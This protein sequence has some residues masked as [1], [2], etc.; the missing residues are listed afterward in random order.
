[1]QTAEWFYP[2]KLNLKSETKNGQISSVQREWS[3]L[4]LFYRQHLPYSKPH[5]SEQLAL[6]RLPTQLTQ[7]NHQLGPIQ[8][9]SLKL[10]SETG[11]QQTSVINE[12]LLNE[13]AKIAA[14]I[15][16]K[17]I[18]KSQL[19]TGLVVAEHARGKGL[20]HRLMNF[21]SPQLL[22]THSYVFAIPELESF[23]QAYG[24]HQA[25]SVSQNN[26]VDNDILQ[27]FNK[28]HSPER[29]LLLMKK[30]TEDKA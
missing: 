14:A 9:G 24:F 21:I 28:Y 18:G 20:A 6:I 10:N 7:S 22:K 29:P 19:I 13:Q 2:S 17:T 5:I 3:E 23:Y 25:I 27:Q 1:M 26:C 15:R 12:G 8:P 30:T 16:I 4:K 11:L